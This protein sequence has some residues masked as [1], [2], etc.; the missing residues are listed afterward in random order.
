MLQRPQHLM[1]RFSRERNVYFFEEFIPTN[2]HL[3]YLEFHSFAGSKVRAVR[4]R[5]PD[6]WSEAERQAGLTEL[7]DDLLELIGRKPPILWFY[8][9]MMFPL[10]RHVAAAAVVYDCMDELANFRFASPLVGELEQELMRRADVVF[11]GGYSLYEAKRLLHDNIHPFPSA[12]DVGHFQSARA[13]SDIPD[14]QAPFARPILGFCGVIDE[15]LDLDL[16]AALADQRPWWSIVFIGP[17]AKIAPE[18]LPRAPNIHYLGQK[19]YARLPAYFAGWDV[20]LMPFAR[21]DAT[22]FISPTKTPEYLAAGLPVVST[23]I[24][25]VVRQYGDINGLFVAADAAAFVQACEAALQLGPKHGDWLKVVDERL[26]TLS[27][28][29]THRRM[30]RLIHEVLDPAVRAPGPLLR[31]VGKTSRKSSRHHRID[32]LIV[33]AGFAGAVLA[34]R[35]A[36]EGK[37]RV[38]VCDRRPHIGGNAYDFYNENGI[39]VHK[40]GPHIFHT[41]SEAIFNYLSRFTAWRHYEHR[42]LAQVDG[43]LL[44]IP[45][46]RTTLNQLYSLDLEDDAAAARYLAGK[47]EPTE[48]IRTSKDVVIAQ[49]G[50]DLYRTFFEGYTRKQWGLDPS[51]LDK[52]VTARIPTRTNTDDRY[53]QDIFQA[54]PKNGYTDMFENMLAGENIEILLETDFRDIRPRFADAHVI[55]TGPIDEFF[56]YEF[57]RL[58]YRSLRFE[59]VTYDQRRLL[60]V[61]VVNFPS[62]AVP[63]TR[64]T[65]FKHIT[66]QIHPKTSACFEYACSQ[67]DPYYPIPRSENQ[68]LFSQYAELARS[69]TDVTFVGRLATYRYYNMDQVVGQALTAF[70]RLQN[71]EKVN[72]GL[73]VR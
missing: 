16:V 2:H 17:I 19:D 15:R 45:I 54:M 70:K 49:V 4:P 5:V 43:K 9:P 7:L 71:K 60:P 47:A 68:K 55:F 63:Y 11:T 3:P 59:H 57:G 33:G 48:E 13:I 26:A 66:G 28:D 12:V 67:G 58:P 65:E 61:G 64:L 39:L 46:N 18:E 14:D 10:A 25:D 38:L 42:V 41:N 72:A 8:T 37:Q 52:A 27:W 51:Q 32:Y 35:L 40:Y 22:R 56:D 69:R 50:T 36:N 6:R 1:Q 62:E 20:A 29:D 44:P 30:D 24:T 73:G 34:E 53:F 31:H 21:N 23:P